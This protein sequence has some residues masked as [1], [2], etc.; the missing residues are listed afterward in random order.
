MFRTIR[1]KIRNWKNDRWKTRNESVIYKLKR[2]DKRVEQFPMDLQKARKLGFL[3]SNKKWLTKAQFEK[4]HRFLLQGEPIEK[5]EE[6]KGH[7]TIM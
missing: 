3:I 7:L 6:N 2:F 4:W 5:I 1:A